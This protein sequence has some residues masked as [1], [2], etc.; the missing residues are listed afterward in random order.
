MMNPLV[1]KM[2]QLK[3][4]D[5]KASYYIAKEISILSL[6]VMW[7]PDDLMNTANRIDSLVE[8][9]SV[10]FKKNDIANSVCVELKELA[11][12]IRE[13]MELNPS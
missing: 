1:R 11:D 4:I 6:N 12:S 3:E 9:I 7:Y 2:L 13:Y 10:T 8:H 5:R